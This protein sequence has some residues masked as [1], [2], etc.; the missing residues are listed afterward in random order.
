MPTAVWR[1]TT[2]HLCLG[3]IATHLCLGLI[4]TLTP[5]TCH[6][7][8][9]RRAPTEQHGAGWRIWDRRAGDHARRVASRAV[10]AEVHEIQQSTIRYK[11]TSAREHQGAPAIRA[12][13]EHTRLTL[14]LCAPGFA[15]LPA[16]P[17]MMRVEGG[18]TWQ[19]SKGEALS[20]Q[21]KDRA[22]QSGAR[23]TGLT[24]LLSLTTRLTRHP[25]EPVCP[26]PAL[27][28]FSERGCTIPNHEACPPPWP[29][30]D[31]SSTKPRPP[32]PPARPPAL[33]AAA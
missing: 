17:R 5:F 25:R 27:F 28:T 11:H 4:A 20:S 8:L 3:L 2:A 15:C 16:G 32:P 23:R 29:P 24:G 31:R 18:R 30:S 12:A 13:Q 7:Q 10:A 9:L 33:R 21:R 26:R 22:E 1:A 6:T 14:S 19:Q